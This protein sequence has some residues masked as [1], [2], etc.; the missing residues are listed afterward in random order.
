MAPGDS[1]TI[2]V[3]VRP[4]AEGDLYSSLYAGNAVLDPNP[5]NTGS[6]EVVHIRVSPAELIGALV[7]RIE[8]LRLIHGVEVVL[9]GW[10]DRARDDFAEG[11]V[12]GACSDLVHF[13][14]M[15]RN[16]P[17]R[18]LSPVHSADL[19]SA[20]T[21]IEAA[22]GCSGSSRSGGGRGVIADDVSFRLRVS[23]GEGGHARIRLSLPEREHARVDVFDVGGRLVRT[24]FEGELAA[25]HHDIA[26]D[27]RGAGGVP[28]GAGIYFLRAVAGANRAVGRLVLLR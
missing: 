24:A 7:D 22:L 3:V 14:R 5:Y 15:V 19:D 1:A 18:V 11:D 23:N 10:L 17:A 28:L 4:Q 20:A 26:W 6:F 13:H 16:F 27:G 8:D 12:P 2:E 9:T 25:G 21:A